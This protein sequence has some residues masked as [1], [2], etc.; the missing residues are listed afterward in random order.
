MARGYT[1]RRLEV[2]ALHAHTEAGA[3]EDYRKLF[4]ALARLDA[5]NRKYISED[6]VVAIPEMRFIGPLLVQLR[7]YEGPPNVQPV[8]YDADEGTER[9]ARVRP[10]EIVV[11][12]THALID[13]KRREAL[14]EY[15]HRGAKASDI[16]AVLGDS[17]RQL[18][19]WR[20]AYIELA[21]QTDKSFLEE[22]D[23]FERI[24][25]TRMRLSRPNIDWTDFSDD[26]AEFAEESDA[27]S[28]QIEMNA[29]RGRSLSMSRGIVKALRSA[30][31]APRSSIQSATVRGRRAGETE[32]TSLSLRDHKAHRRV[33][34]KTDLNGHVVDEE[35]EKKLVAYR[36]ERR[37][38]RS[39][40]S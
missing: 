8:V 28:G 22:L 4:R 36:K 15:N 21:P 6:K 13:L 35:I 37:A 31:T 39:E 33:A 27:Q 25:L 29:R 10:G 20:S 18:P 11:T 9:L 32:E 34:V 5:Q 24:R 23:R 3:V 30:V 19:A 7:A 12:K 16:A 17:A 40:P 1:S 38:Q 2:W 14:V 26:F